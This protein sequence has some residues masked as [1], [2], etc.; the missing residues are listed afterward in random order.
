MTYCI[1]FI[2]P[3]NDHRNGAGASR[4]SCESGWTTAPADPLVVWLAALRVLLARLL[5]CGIHHDNGSAAE[6]FTDGATG[7][8]PGIGDLTVVRFRRILGLIRIRIATI[9]AASSK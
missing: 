2:E 7:C 6:K 9:A 3:D 1:G 8:H 4:L 5:A